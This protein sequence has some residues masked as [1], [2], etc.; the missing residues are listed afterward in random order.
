[1]LKSI[2]HIFSFLFTFR[3]Q[4]IP[5]FERFTSTFQFCITLIIIHTNSTLLY[6]N[7]GCFINHSHAQFMLIIDFL[8]SYRQIFVL[9]I[10]S[11]WFWNK[12]FKS[13]FTINKRLCNP[14][15]LIYKEQKLRVIYDQCWSWYSIHN[16]YT[17]AATCTAVTRRTY[18]WTQKQKVGNLRQR[19]RWN[20]GVFLWMH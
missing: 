4:F 13:V 5:H 2:F 20:E 6:V 9:L 1:M 7:G 10:F 16:T 19:L 11:S 8:S 17:S 14:C 12:Y 18:N 3:L 15:W